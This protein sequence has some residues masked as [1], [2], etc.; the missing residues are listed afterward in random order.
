MSIDVLITGV[1]G[2]VGSHLAP[3]LARQSRSVAGTYYKP[4]TVLPANPQGFALLEMDIRYS[5]HVAATIARLRPQTIFH[6]AAQSY[7]TVS[8]ER[9]QETMDTNVLGTVN[10]YEAIR[11]LRAADRSYDPVVVAA[12]SSAQYGAS[13]L[14][15]NGPVTEDAQFLPLHPYGVSKVATDLLAFQYFKSDGIR[16]IRA[17]IFNTSGPRKSGDVISD[18]ARRVAALPPQGGRLRVGNLNSRRAFMH[19]DDLIAALL[20]LASD[21][22]AGEAYN[23]SGAEVVSIGELIPMF[24]A[25]AGCTIAPDVDAALLRP[26]DEPIIM[27]SNAKITR[28]TGWTPQRPVRELV[29][30]VYAHE[31]AMRA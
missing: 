4:T 2:M 6:L 24:E 16:S 22:H 30:D 9:P 29:G 8:W 18:F 10:L 13:L 25:A 15:A 27:G 23:V 17:R 1:G 28:D 7:P 21:G 20:A 26:T 5:Q 31:K 11:Q 3:L 19:V 14:T 12:C